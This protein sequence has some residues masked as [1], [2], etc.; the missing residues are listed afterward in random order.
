MSVFLWARY[1]CRK[2]VPDSRGRVVTLL[3]SGFA[4]WTKIITMNCFPKAL[5]TTTGV[6]RSLKLGPLPEDCYR[7]LGILLLQ[8]PRGTLFLMSE[9]PL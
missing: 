3:A 9:V 8:A 1:S 6:P 4:V 2:L 7:A 5:V